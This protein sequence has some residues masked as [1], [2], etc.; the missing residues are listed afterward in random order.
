LLPELDDCPQRRQWLLP[1]PLDFHG[2][3]FAF[4]IHEPMVFRGFFYAEPF[5]Y[6][7]IIIIILGS[8]TRSFFRRSIW[9]ALIVYAAYNYNYI[10]LYAIFERTY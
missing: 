10:I 5:A 1:L 7:I 3:D 8:S 4:D 2:F 9:L 6:I